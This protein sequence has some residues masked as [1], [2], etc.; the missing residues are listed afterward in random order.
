[1]RRNI[2]LKKK[3]KKEIVLIIIGLILFFISM[4]SFIV[5]A[6]TI[7]NIP[8]AWVL[9]TVIFI[10]CI[11]FIVGIVLFLINNKEKI[12]NYLKEII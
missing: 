4:L 8:L 9:L 10:S 12:K 5:N 7:Q 11:L 2:K 1:M 6:C 3:T